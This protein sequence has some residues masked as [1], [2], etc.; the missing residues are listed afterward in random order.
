MLSLLP[1]NILTENQGAGSVGRFFYFFP[2]YSSLILFMNENL[3][4]SA[5]TTRSGSCEV[6]SS[7]GIR[8][9][10]GSIGDPAVM[11][12]VSD[13]SAGFTP[14]ARA[15]NRGGRGVLYIR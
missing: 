5:T 4:L 10:G 6:T 11:L 2:L 1:T 14:T 13:R 7:G 3:R 8:F 9:R 15:S 12:S